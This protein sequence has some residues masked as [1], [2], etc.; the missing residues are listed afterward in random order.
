[1]PAD[2]PIEV[3]YHEPGARL[4]AVLFGPIFCSIALIV[5]LLTG[6]VVHWI[7][8]PLF[9]AVLS[10]LIYVQVIAARRHASVRLTAATLWQGTEEVPLAEIVEIYP[11]PDDDAYDDE[12]EPWETARALGELS[13]IPRR[14]RG[15]GLRLS[16]G[17]VVQAW[18][19]DDKALRAALVAA[20]EGNAD[21]NEVTDE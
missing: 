3:L 20:V 10:G 21:V 4:R 12:L 1:M 13:T 18:A 19:K 9:A 7:T 15:I 14:R 16:T 2:D 6:P 11:E 8:L 5:E 17:G